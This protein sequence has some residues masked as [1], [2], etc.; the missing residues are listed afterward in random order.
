MEKLVATAQPVM[1]DV[2]TF[3]FGRQGPLGGVKFDLTDDRFDAQP[4]LNL[5]PKA[6]VVPFETIISICTSNMSETNKDLMVG[7]LADA[8]CERVEHFLS[9]ARKQGN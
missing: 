7:L 3:S 5:L 1:K 2:L 6:L 4:S 9:Q 8:C